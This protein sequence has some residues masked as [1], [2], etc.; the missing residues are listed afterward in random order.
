MATVLIRSG[1]FL[2]PDFV[3]GLGLQTDEVTLTI[4]A[5]GTEAS[6][7]FTGGFHQGEN[8]YTVVYQGSGFGITS[9]GRY[10]GIVTGFVATDQNDNSWT[11]TG[12]H[13][14]LDTI[15]TTAV[16]NDFVDNLLV[17]LTWEYHGNDFDDFYIGGSF[18]DTLLGAGGQDTFQG[19]DGNDSITGDDGDDTLN[20]EA[21]DDSLYGGDDNDV[22][23][24]GEDNDHLSGGNGRDLIEGETGSDTICGGAGI[25]T[26]D[27]GTGQDYIYGGAGIDHINGGLGADQLSGGKANDVIEG[28][29]GGD[30][31]YG[32]SD[33]DHL[34][35]QAGADFV[36]GGGGDDFVDGGT[37]SDRVWGGSGDD[38]VQGGTSSDFIIGGLGDD[39]LA[40]NNALIATADESPDSFLFFLDSIGTDTITDFETAWDSIYLIGIDET[41]V[42]VSAGPEDVSVEIANT[43]GITTETITIEGVASTFVDD[44]DILYVDNNHFDG[45]I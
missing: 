21:G 28:G 23:R 14:S 24:G 34:Q 7:S 27:G 17:P 9:E 25:D 42:N 10:T 43:D 3:R 39:V 5:E 32:Y 18:N 12:Y 15:N 13:T 30:S 20:G 45:L 4:N 1:D 41:N 16:Y 37:S 40:G 38:T 8:T 29:D 35:G 36:A 6:L 19:L 22:L 31:I 44:I 26:L 2:G 11:V 33:N